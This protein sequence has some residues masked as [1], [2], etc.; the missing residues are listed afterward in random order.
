MR[1]FWILERDQG[2]RPARSDCRA[3]VF[4]ST[5]SGDAMCVGRMGRLHD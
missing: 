2:S 4:P 5:I 1:Q 3:N